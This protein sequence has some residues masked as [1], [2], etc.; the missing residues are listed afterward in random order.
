M[1]VTTGRG[2]IANVRYTGDEA[3]GEVN[4]LLHAVVSDQFALNLP[5]L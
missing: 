1:V 3:P 4:K 5:K 2:N